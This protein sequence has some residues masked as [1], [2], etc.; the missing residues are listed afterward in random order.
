MNDWM[1]VKQLASTI[2]FDGEEDA[3]IW[4][5]ST[6]GV[7][8]SQSLYKAINF[9]GVTPVHVPAVWN[10]TIP[11]RVQFFL[12]LLSRNKNLTRDNLESRG[13]ILDDK[14][15]LFCAGRETSQHLFFECV[16]ARQM[17]KGISEALGIEIGNGFE[18]IG[19]LWLSNKR[20]LVHN[21]LSS[22]SL[23]SLWKLRND[24]R[25]QNA[26][27]RSVE[28]LLV[29]IA[30]TVQNWIIVCPAELKNKLSGSIGELKR[31][32]SRPGRITG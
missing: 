10:L 20:F 27:W 23:W 5:F 22:V 4:M 28:T 19:R 32:A 30:M 9:R 29:R 21:M 14:S 11:T 6:K 17:W 7:Y 2:S 24:L 26:S 12:W 25:F 16:V 3:L 8:S 18:T 15:C 1:E 31:I 13:K